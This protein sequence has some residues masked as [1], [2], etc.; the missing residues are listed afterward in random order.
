MKYKIIV[1]TN[2]FIHYF[3]DGDEASSYL[4]DH[5]DDFGRFLFSH[6]TIGELLYIL[7]KISHDYH[8]TNEDIEAIL[9]SA[10]DMFLYGKSVSTK[11][12]NVDELPVIRD[13]DDQMF[14]ELAYAGNADYIISYDKRSGLFDLENAPFSC[15]TPKEFF[16]EKQ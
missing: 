7:K 16:K 10:V 11:L 1:D 6:N 14:I 9:H 2:V 8:F 4:I 13:H 12:I 3:F 5:I 15:Y